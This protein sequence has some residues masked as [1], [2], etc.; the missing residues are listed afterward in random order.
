VRGHADPATRRETEL[1]EPA[2]HGLAS[3]TLLLL[4]LSLATG[5]ATSPLLLPLGL[6]L[7][8]LVRY[9]DRPGM[10]YAPL[11][12]ALCIALFELWLGD[13]ALQAL[14]GG[15]AVAATILPA[16]RWILEHDRAR[17]QLEH[18][19]DILAQ[20]RRGVAGEA[21][22]AAEELADLELALKAVAQR[23]GARSV[24]LWDVDAVLDRAHVRAAS[25]GRTRRSIHLRGDPLGWVWEQGM[26]LRVEPVPLWAE[27][28]TVVLADRLRQREDRGL[29]V[30]YAFEPAHVPAEE[31]PLD[32]SAIY[33]RATLAYQEARTTAASN[34]RR[35][36]A[37]LDGL[38]MMPGEL[39]LDAFA[40]DLCSTAASMTDATGAAVG[41]WS[42]ESGTG[43]IIATSGNDGGP[44]P[45][46]TFAPPGSELGLAVR[47]GAM[48]VRDA[49]TWSLDR[50]AVADAGERWAR[51]PRALATLPLRSGK[52][53]IG[54]LA[55]WSSSQPAL[56]PEALDLLNA[57]A[58]YAAL[59]IEHS[60]QY[61]ALHESADRDPLTQLRNRRG[62]DRTFAE[63]EARLARHARP[64]SLLVL[65]LDHFKNVN[66]TYGHE[67]G[68]I[69][70]TRVARLIE[71]GIRDVDVAARFGGEEFVV[72]LPETPLAAAFD[73]AERI[74]TAVSDARIEWKGQLIP[75]RVS[76][77]VS[78][79]P[80]RV[81]LPADLLSSADAALYRAKE[82]GRNR[83][84]VAGAA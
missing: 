68:D 8:L 55:V 36:R 47:A 32:Q 7:I 4:V 12:A 63:A 42:P 2:R 48:L 35:V 22:E 23:I 29:L 75:V 84:V 30:T 44:R 66:D 76:I 31:T 58:P 27:Q 21:P 40:A 46:D 9:Y 18:L 15:A 11:A 73:V 64:L 72:M 53:V 51:R 25:Q 49:A 70:L 62:F 71:A 39:N 69:V 6:L 14:L 77:G 81:A 54:V 74:R 33:L 80:E 52:G 17:S 1:T 79:C 24:M 50:T 34:E 26:R 5:G 28:G 38:R 61:D 60:L 67:A 10:G 82:S 13:G 37:L 57:L 56:E 16:W 3:G 19:D 43:R 41:L 83:V 65:D 78:C 20:A 59:H 45:G